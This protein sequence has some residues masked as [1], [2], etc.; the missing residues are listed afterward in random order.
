MG[1]GWG[2]V[3]LRRGA[4][5]LRGTG[6]SFYSM[7]CPHHHPLR[8]AQNRAMSLNVVAVSA[9][10]RLRATLLQSP[11]R[12]NRLCFGFQVLRSVPCA[13]PGSHRKRV[14]Q[15]IRFVSKLLAIPSLIVTAKGSQCIVSWLGSQRIAFRLFSTSL[16]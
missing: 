15:E 11:C 5:T 13:L 4:P 2:E 12:L 6:Y 1:R 14:F 16:G 3:P 10:V 9:L 8:Q 7:V